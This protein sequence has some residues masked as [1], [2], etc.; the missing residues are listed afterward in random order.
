MIR[1]IAI[2]LWLLA[3]APGSLERATVLADP[4]DHY[5]F[6]GDSYLGEADCPNLPAL[7]TTG[8]VRTELPAGARKARVRWI[9]DGDTIQVSIGHDYFRV[10]V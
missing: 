2:V 5:L 10:R 3:F 7:D 4:C 9:Y 6:N 1:M 8:V